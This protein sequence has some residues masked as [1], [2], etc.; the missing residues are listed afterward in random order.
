[1]NDNEVQREINRQMEEKFK[2]IVEW[3]KSVDK[4]LDNHLHDFGGRMSNVEND[5]AWLKRIF[6]VFAGIIGSL[7][8]S[9]IGL[10][11]R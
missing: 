8:V 6:W 7:S 10:I 3:V 11:F 5:M 4:K 2:E 9:I 1:M